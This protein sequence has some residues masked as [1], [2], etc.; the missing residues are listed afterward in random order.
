MLKN[1][2]CVMYNLKVDS[3]SHTFSL[4]SRRHAGQI[5]LQREIHGFKP[6]YLF[7]LF[8]N[9]LFILERERERAQAGRG[10][11]REGHRIGS[12]VQSLSCQHR[13]PMQGSNSQAMRS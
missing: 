12:R 11:V 4:S 9:V 10:R 8:L 13:A 2:L 6:W 3:F 7:F 5:E 1:V